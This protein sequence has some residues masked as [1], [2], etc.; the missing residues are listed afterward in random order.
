[1]AASTAGPGDTPSSRSRLSVKSANCLA[2]RVM[3]SGQSIEADQQG[4][5]ILVERTH[6]RC[7]NGILQSRSPVRPAT[8][9]RGRPRAEWP[10]M[11]QQLGVAPIA[12]TSE[13]LR[14]LGA[15]CRPADLNPTRGG[16]TASL[17]VPLLTTSTSTTV[18]AGS[19]ITTG[20]PAMDPSGPRPCRS[21][22]R[23][24]RSARMG[25]SASEK[26]REASWRRVGARSLKIRYAK[27][28]PALT[29]P[30][31]VG[32]ARASHESRAAKKLNGQ[33]HVNAPILVF[34][35][36]RST[37]SDQRAGQPWVTSDDATA[38]EAAA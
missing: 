9:T 19:R 38:G 11:R 15:R 36:R 4:L 37:P 34:A 32:I 35:R 26:S 23:L 27:Q 12:A 10:Q 29:T 13:R 31:L 16:L 25:S 28:G 14:L 5:M 1:M 24:H 20:S 2:A 33:P 3:I 6:R 21:S 22:E 7:A 8:S 30:E 17:H 18:S